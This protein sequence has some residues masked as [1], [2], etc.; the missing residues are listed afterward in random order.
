MEALPRVGGKSVILTV[1]DC[2]SKYC[3]FIS[4]AHPYTTESVVQVYFAEVVHLH[5]VPQ[6]M[7]ADRNL[8]FTSIVWKELMCLTGA[9]LH[10]VGISP[11]SNGQTEAANK[12]IVM[13]LNCLT[14]DCPRQ[15]L[16]WIP[17]TEYVYNT[18]FLSALKE[19]PFK[20]VYGSDPP[21]VCSY[22]PGE[23]RVAVVAK[24]MAER[25]G[26]LAD[27]RYRL[28]QAQAV[29]KLYYDKHHREAHYLVDD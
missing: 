16:R 17:W 8:V 23:T 1:V 4:L 27:V 5:N 26:L 12:V 29:Y 19:T 13:Y 22:E 18:P 24:I 3:H 9:K 28:E 7:V 10:I 2:F 6:S 25:D 21:S 14:G 15:W 20:I 11:H